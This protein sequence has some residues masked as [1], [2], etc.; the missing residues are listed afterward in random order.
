[1][2]AL[3]L[4]AATR[5]GLSLGHCLSWRDP[6]T[7]CTLVV[8]QPSTD[9]DLWSEYSVGAQRSY[10]KHGVESAL[11]LEALHSG[12]DTAMF[13]AVIDD[14]GRM[15]GGVRAKGP[16]RS[17]DDSHAVVEWAGQPGQRAVR[18][19]IADRIPFGVLEMKSAW[20]NDDPDRSRVLSRA[21]ARSAFH[22]MVML[23]L[24]FSM[25]TAATSLLNRW[26][27]SGGVVAALPATPYPDERYRTKMLWL[28]RRDFFH[29]AEPDQ[30]AKI[31]TETKH[32]IHE[33]YRRGEVD[34]AL[35]KRT[36]ITEAQLIRPNH[37]EV[38]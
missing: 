32:L 12:A 15:V 28:N 27:S 4:G 3:S 37:S 22:M 21:L 10:R 30:V 18:N 20:I 26:R 19:M 16:L 29:H 17:A 13:F 31:V 34:A 23:D 24:Q 2:S 35:S 5:E 14:D 33:L 8:S 38:A 6:D 9:P 25:A 11:D 7:D 36:T 1:M